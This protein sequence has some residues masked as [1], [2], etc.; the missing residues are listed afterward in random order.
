MS[1]PSPTPLSGFGLGLRI[2]HYNDFIET[3]QPVDFLEVISENFMVDGGKP[4]DV[5][6]SIRER[7][8]VVLHGVSMNIGSGDGTDPGYLRRLRRL[9][10][11]IQPMWVSDHL[12]W[13][14]VEGFNSH[15][16]LPL[17][18]TE[19][20][21]D[22]VASNVHA[23]QDALGR[24]L[25]LENPS[26]Y[27]AFPEAGMSEAAFLTELCA[28]TGCY[29]LLD[30]NNIYVSA[31]NHGL[32]ADD[33]LRRLPLDRVL[34]IHLAGHSQGR[35]MLIDTH[36]APVCDPVWALYS[37]FVERLGDVAVMIERDDHIP[38]LPE[39]L[40]ELARARE[41]AHQARRRAA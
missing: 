6:A 38:P 12:C 14:G 9:A 33:W 22:L 16:L 24:A 28:R 11:S 25:V 23:A 2:P 35:D 4:L 18:Y 13:T 30:V 29:L 21:L 39:L 17:P 5:L 10:D 19:E 34:Q 36:D 3:A 40:T 31:T 26:T 32:D 41:L 15:D 8:P 1:H 27:L 7:Y 37:R 20:A